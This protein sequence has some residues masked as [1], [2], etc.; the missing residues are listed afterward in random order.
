MKLILKSFPDLKC[1]K[2]FRQFRWTE[3]GEIFKSR[4]VA[5]PHHLHADPSLD[6]G[7]T[8]CKC[9]SGKMMESGSGVI[10]FLNKRRKSRNK[11]K[12]IKTVPRRENQVHVANADLQWGRFLQMYSAYSSIQTAATR[13]Q[14]LPV[15]IERFKKLLSRLSCLESFR[16]L[17]ADPPVCNKTVKLAGK[18]QEYFTAELWSRS[19]KQRNRN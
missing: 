16:I 9:G 12:H 7:P 3:T 15:S 19:R 14:F 18:K 4:S 8:N 13:L 11:Q 6:P 17:R 1:N 2:A 10:V 5:D